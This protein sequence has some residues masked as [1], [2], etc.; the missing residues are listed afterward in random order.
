MQMNDNESQAYD[1]LT[2]LY[3]EGE[4]PW[5]DPL[6]PPEVVSYVSTLPPGRALDLGCGYGRAA[7]HLA[8][9]GW[10]VD[11][12]DFVPQALA[13]AKERATVAGQVVRFHQAQITKL[14]FLRGPYQFA[15]DVGCCHN[16]DDSNLRIYHDHLVRLLAPGGIFML[17][18]RIHG[19]NGLVDDRGPAGLVKERLLELFADEFSVEWISLGTT[20]VAG[21]PKWVSGWFRWSKKTNG[22]L[23]A[24]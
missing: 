12:V 6:P 23:L 20:E 9:L 24:D 4:I 11:A 15:L 3:E 17:F 16:L 7:I 18:A 8:S 5:D 13:I 19:E 2:S 1:R 14:D 22:S 10:D 21:Q